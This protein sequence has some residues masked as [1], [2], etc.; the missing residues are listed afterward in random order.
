MHF[1]V[2]VLY[3]DIAKKHYTGQGKYI[4][5]F[6]ATHYWLELCQKQDDQMPFVWQPLQFQELPYF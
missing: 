2:N 3:S 1:T 5:Q 4:A 6:Y